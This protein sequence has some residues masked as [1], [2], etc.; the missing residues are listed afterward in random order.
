[1]QQSSTVLLLGV[2]ALAGCSDRPTGPAP[3]EQRLSA[4]AAGVPFSEEL[5]SPAWQAGARDQGAGA[6]PNP[7][8]ATRGYA[9]LGVATHRALLAGENGE[10]EPPTQPGPGNGSGRGGPERARR[11]GGG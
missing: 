2:A 6:R 10:G 9:T 5:A 4:S 1:M 11:G 3:S 7:V 8:A